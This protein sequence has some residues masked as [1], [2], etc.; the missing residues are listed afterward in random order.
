MICR[1]FCAAFVT[2]SL[3]FLAGADDKKD[4]PI[5]PKDTIK[6]FNGKDLS[7]LYTWIKDTK[8]EDPKKVFSVQ[9]GVIRVAGMPMGYLATDKDYENYHLTV[10]FKWGKEVY[11][12]KGV[13]NSGILLHGSGVDGGNGGTWMGSIECQLAQGCIGDLIPIGGKDAKGDRI[14]TQFTSDSAAGEDKHLR[15]KKGGEAKVFA[16]GQQWWEKHQNFFK[17]EID[18]RGKE[19]VDS[20]LG[21]WTKMECICDGKRITIKVNGKTVNECYDCNPSSG[22]ILLQS[23]GFE[24]FF[25][26]FELQPLKK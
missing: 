16:K 1:V 24:I 21:E 4:G 7:G 6:L 12:A 25:R 18:T 5:T 22:K 19:D 9:D 26:N 2:L 11:G 17:E 3:A 10:E 15:W 8:R 20:P 13:R 14:T 23:E